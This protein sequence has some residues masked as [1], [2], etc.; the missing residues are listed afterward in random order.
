MKSLMTKSS[1]E[2]LRDRALRL[3]SRRDHSVRELKTKLKQRMSFEESDFE[4]VLEYLAKFNYLVSQDSLAARYVKEWRSQG[5][6]RHWI[7]GKL[8]TKG[9]PTANLTDDDEEREAAKSF[10]AKKLRLN[11]LSKMPYAERA[12]IGRSLI[13]RGFSSTLVATLIHDESF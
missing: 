9:L 7:N 3:L 5:K 8:K 13:S 10:L 1:Y 6:G 11:A 2:E 12:R 4:K